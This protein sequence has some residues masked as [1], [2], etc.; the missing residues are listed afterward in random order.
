MEVRRRSSNFLSTHSSFLHSD[1]FGK[2]SQIL[3]LG[4]AKF[5]NVFTIHMFAHIMEG[6]PSGGKAK[7]DFAPNFE[8]V[9]Y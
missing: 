2:Y 8:D 7:L 3:L 9:I 5:D 6:D 4:E 1:N